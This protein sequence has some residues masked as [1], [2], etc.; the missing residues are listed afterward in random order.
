[1]GFNEADFRA[2]SGLPQFRRGLQGWNLTK[3]DIL[4]GPQIGHGR[5]GGIGSGAVAQQGPGGKGVVVVHA[6]APG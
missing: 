1:M 4:C 5:E 2:F 6:G 3:L